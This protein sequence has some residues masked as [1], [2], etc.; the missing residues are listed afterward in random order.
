MEKINYLPDPAHSKVIACST[1]I[2][3][4]LPIMPPGLAYQKMEFGL[5]I[6]PQKLNQALQEAIDA[7]G[8]EIKTVILGYGLCSRAVAGLVSANCR[9]II[10]RVD[11]CIGLFLGS[12]DEYNLQHKNSPGTL[13][14]TKGWIEAGTPL[15]EREEM[16]KRYGEARAR[17]L[18]KQMIRNYTRL[19][20][21]NTGNYEIAHYR[22]KSR[23]V[24]A[25]L[26]LHF[27]EI[28]GSN[29]L[30]RR[31]LYGP[32]DGDFVIAPPGQKITFMDFRIS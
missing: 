6:N 12:V 11:D 30:I 4:M 19:V 25:E 3:E 10:P 20:F 9:L 26:E 7:C 31:S 24:A 15:A 1:V 21:I 16:S 17:S 18:Y 28:K 29:S 14:L 22:E 32:W 2:E 5:H 23:E 8:P 27:E 13:Y